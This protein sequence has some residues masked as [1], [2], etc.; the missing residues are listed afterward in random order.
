MFALHIR[1]PHLYEIIP[2]PR[3]WMYWAVNPQ[4]R[5]LMPSINGRDEFTFHTQLRA[6]TFA[7]S[8]A[9]ISLAKD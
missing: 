6:R 1:S 3:A 4:R 7:R 8:S 9:A 2:Y 5:A